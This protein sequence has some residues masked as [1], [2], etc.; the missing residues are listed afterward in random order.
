MSDNVSPLS[1]QQNAATAAGT[2]STQMQAFIT[3]LSALTNL[4]G[5]T[6][7]TLSDT[8]N[9]SSLQASIQLLLNDAS[10]VPPTLATTPAYTRPTAPT[11]ISSNAVITPPT[12]VAPSLPT[13][14]NPVAPVVGTAPFTSALATIDFPVVPNAPTISL[15]TVPVLPTITVTAPNAPSVSLPS[16]PSLAD[17]AVTTPVRPALTLPAA[18][19]FN[20]IVMPTITSIT[21]PTLTALAPSELLPDPTDLFAFSES[22]YSSLLL[23]AGQQKLANDLANGGYGIET[24]DELA[25]WQRAQDRELRAGVAAAADIARA[26]AARGFAMP[27]GAM[28]AQMASSNQ[29]TLEKMSTLSRDTALKRADMYVENRKF[30]IDQAREYEALTTALYSAVMERALNASKATAE[31]GIAVYNA[32][33]AKFDALTKAFSVQVQ[34][35]GEEVRA[36]VATLE[37]QRLSL[38]VVRTETEVQKTQ[39]QL[40][41][42]QIEAQKLP[43]EIYRTDAQV[44]Q[45]LA[46]T[47][48]NV[49]RNQVAVYSAE[50]DA[51][52]IPVELYRTEAQVQQILADTQVNVQRNQISAYIAETEAQKVLVDMYRTDISALEGLAQVE[53]LKLDTFRCQVEAYAEMI[54]AQTLQL[55]GYEAQTRGDMVQ[56]EIYKTQ[57]DAQLVQ[58]EYAKAQAQINEA[59]TQIAVENLK[60]NLAIIQT[61]SDV[62]RAQAQGTSLTNDAQSRSF[63]ARTEAFRSVASAYDSLGKIEIAGAEIQLKAAYESQ[64]LSNDYS[65]ALLQIDAN[66][67]I[68]GAQVLAQT[69]QANLGQVLAIATDVNNFTAAGGSS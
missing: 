33:L 15:P 3:Q 38:E 62:Y 2:A 21:L 45:M 36:A 30:T 65:K 23:L 54:R 44:Q 53:H 20:N 55:Q 7:F 27:P 50:M 46:D 25:I 22:G 61:N 43:L 18:P 31:F 39:A 66:N 13:L 58:A 47:Q 56:A 49:Q 63:A 19:V 41:L 4:P 6:K 14:L 8:L 68:A 32:S 40:Y 9:T 12:F 57:V 29:A 34:A 64:F 51:Q 52:R 60:A 48:V 26:M 5:N 42:D 10:L 59:N 28:L 67:A 11:P 16:V 69:V 1:M 35:Y 24:A 37:V 17:I